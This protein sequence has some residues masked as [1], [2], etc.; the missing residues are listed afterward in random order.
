MAVD[1]IIFDFDGVVID[2]E[3]PDYELWREFFHSEGLEL[4]VELWLKRVGT[5]ETESFSPVEHYK[6]LTGKALDD[7][8]TNGHYKR[9]LD[10][11][12]Q[13]PLLDG[14][15][16]L[17]QEASKRGIKL[18]VASSSYLEWVGPRL[19]QHHLWQYFD[20]IRTRDD[21]KMGKPAPDLYLSAAECLGVPVARCI[22]IEDSP[23]GMKAALAA[24]M[25]CIAVPNQ[26]TN[27]LVRPEVAITVTSLAEYTLDRILAEF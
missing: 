26:L 11:C 15:E 1:A 5:N 16:A 21:V 14:V 24:G 19:K 8:Y 25:R 22:A 6:A 23:N 13:Q 3:T 17:I 9:Y 10:R 18:A 12:D 7:S 2:T 20:C 4:P 27:Q